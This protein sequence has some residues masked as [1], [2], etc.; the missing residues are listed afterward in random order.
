M[1]DTQPKDELTSRIFQALVHKRAILLTKAARPEV[2]E[3]DNALQANF[4]DQLS[5]VQLADMWLFEASTYE[6]QG[7]LDAALKVY[8]K[9]IGLQAA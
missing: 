5:P 9:I 3:V 8:D 7:D 4:A 2:I 1:T 6:T